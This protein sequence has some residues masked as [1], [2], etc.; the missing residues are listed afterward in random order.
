MANRAETG[1]ARP[2]D[3]PGRAAIFFGFRRVRVRH[4]GEVARVELDP[5]ELGR[6]ADPDLRSRMAEGIRSAGFRF[7]TIDLDGYRTGGGVS[8]GPDLYRIE[9][10]RDNG[11]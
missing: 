9:P 6:C 4:H 2:A 3:L 5:A 7:A 10:A 1:G 8:R 11:Q